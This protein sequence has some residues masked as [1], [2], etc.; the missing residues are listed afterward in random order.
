MAEESYSHGILGRWAVVGYGF[1]IASIASSIFVIITVVTACIRKREAYNTP[2]F[3]LS[4]W[5]AACDI[6]YSACQLCVFEN[7][8]M[9][10]LSETRLRV[11]H[12]LMSGSTMSFVFMSA[13]MALHVALVTATKIGHIAHRIQPWYEFASL[14]VGFALTH[15]ILYLYKMLQW[16][17]RAQIFHIYDDPTYYKLTAWL[18]KWSWLFAACVLMFVSMI[19]VFVKMVKTQKIVEKE[20]SYPEHGCYL[21]DASYTAIGGNRKQHVRSVTLRLMLYSAVPILTQI[22]VLSANMSPEC[23]MWLYVVANLAPATQGIINFLIFT[24]HPTWDKYRKKAPAS[25]AEFSTL[26]GSSI[27]STHLDLESGYDLS[28][29]ATLKG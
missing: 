24:T 25:I 3:R 21:N 10:T 22:W 7:A 29:P 5:I 6:V 15:P 17:S 18:T 2:S 14:F 20:M 8:Y 16:S 1:N 13:C 19:I 28:R 26:K 9:S 27:G 11:I 12:W 23:P 4:A